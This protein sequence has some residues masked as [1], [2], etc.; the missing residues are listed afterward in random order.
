[1]LIWVGLKN[2]KRENGC[3]SKRHHCDA[4]HAL[5]TADVMADVLCSSFGTWVRTLSDF[6]MSLRFH[7]KNT[8]S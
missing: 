7:E 5:K 1:M 3:R 2:E 4:K 8:T 6:P